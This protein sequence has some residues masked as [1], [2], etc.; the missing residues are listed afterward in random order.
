MHFKMVWC[1]AVMAL[2]VV[3]TGALNLYGAELAIGNAA[4]STDGDHYSVAFP[5]TLTLEE[6]QNRI[7]GVNFEIAYSP[8]LTFDS[9]IPGSTVTEAVKTVEDNTL[10]SDALRVVVYGVRQNEIPGGIIATLNFDVATDADQAIALTFSRAEA[11]DIGAVKVATTTSGY[12][13][14]LADLG[15]SSVTGTSDADG[16]NSG[17][18]NGCFIQAVINY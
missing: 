6:G 13:G 10:S 5:V 2:G 16:S 3:F 18:D 9:V 11:A 14:T 7:A 15:I 4:V 17:S 8:N 1:L 12:S